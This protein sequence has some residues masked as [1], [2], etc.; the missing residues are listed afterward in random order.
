MVYCFNKRPSNETTIFSDNDRIKLLL[1]EF[2]LS[3]RLKR[4]TDSTFENDYS[5]E[6]YAEH[7]NKFRESSWGY[8]KSIIE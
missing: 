8:L 2:G 3:S 4:D 5:P 1:D 6:D 7:L